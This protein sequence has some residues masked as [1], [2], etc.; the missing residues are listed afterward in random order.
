MKTKNIFYTVVISIVIIVIAYLYAHIDKM[1]ILYDKRVDTSEY[2]PTGIIGEHVVEQTFI[3]VEDALDGIY[4]KCQIFGDVSEVVLKYHLSEEESGKIV[5]EGSISGNDI[6]G[7]L[8]TKLFFDKKVTGCI[9]KG[10]TFK[11]W[12]ENPSSERGVGFSYEQKV[13]DG[14]KFAIDG[15]ERNGTMIAKTITKRFDME[16]FIVLIAFILFIGAFIRVLYKLFK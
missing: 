8:F 4:I 1:N 3:A 5:A 10:Y 11:I 16:T 7:N 6:N 13:E 2:M 15:E 12:E 14:T 9:N